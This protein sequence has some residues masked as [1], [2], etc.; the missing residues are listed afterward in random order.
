MIISGITNIGA[1]K[2]FLVILLISLLALLSGTRYHL[3]GY[4]YSNYE[5]MFR[6][7]PNLSNLNVIAYIRENGLIGNDVGWTLLNSIIKSMGFNFYGLTLFVAIFFWF[8]FYF[9]LR[10]YINNLNIFIV[11]AM[12]KYL[13]DVSFIYMRQSVAVAIFILSIRYILKRKLILYMLLVVLAATIHF[14]A[15]ILIPIYWITKIKI[16]RKG[17]LWYSIIFSFSFILVIGRVDILSKLDFFSQLLSGSGAQKIS[18]AANGTLY[19]EVSL[20]SSGLHLVEFL[21]VDFALI[22]N[23]DKLKLNNE[24]QLLMVK[25]YMLMLPI[26]TIFATSPIIVRYGFYFLFT[27]A[28]IID[29]LISK[30]NVLNKIFLYLLLALV[31]F[32]G[33]YKFVV[34]F[35]NGADL[36][37]D[38]FIFHDESIRSYS[39][40]SW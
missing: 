7:V 4:D 23:F 19:G 9:V 30:T 13:L 6:L 39:N 22:K 40:N 16:T 24:K 10:N 1:I 2:N 20:L 18:E 21:I 25:L 34:G 5:Y 14:S 17:L 31:S 27:Y 26:Y 35:D 32:L 29:W 38:S 15:V 12:Y 36:H 8:T 11:I 33:M 37:Y 28:V 3:G